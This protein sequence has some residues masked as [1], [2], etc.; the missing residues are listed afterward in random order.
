MV[1][2]I[3]GSGRWAK[4]IFK[5]CFFELKIKMTS[6]IARLKKIKTGEQNNHDFM[7]AVFNIFNVISNTSYYYYGYKRRSR[8]NCKIKASL[9]ILA[10]S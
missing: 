8:Q 6:L 10:T 5:V 3:V 7:N 1:V 2:Y 4:E 9:T